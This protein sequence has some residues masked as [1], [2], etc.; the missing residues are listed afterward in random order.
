MYGGRGCI[1]PHILVSS[2]L[3]LMLFTA[4]TSRKYARQMHAWFSQPFLTAVSS[5]YWDKSSYVRKPDTFR[6]VEA[7]GFRRWCITLRITGFLDLP[8]IPNSKYYKEQ[9]FEIWTLFPISGEGMEAPTLLGPLEIANLNHWTK[10]HVQRL[11]LALSEGTNIGVFIP[12]PEDGSRSV[13]RKVVFYSYFEFGTVDKVQKPNY[14]D[15]S[16]L[17]QK[18]QPQILTL[19]LQRHARLRI[20]NSLKMS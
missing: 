20:W 16:D 3:L 14:S 15:R 8:I 4:T 13:F 7:K 2:R 9:R 5:I 18:P 6:L 17:F 1:N 10:A 19:T 11:R 12:S